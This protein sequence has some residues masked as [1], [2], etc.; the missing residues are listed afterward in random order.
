MNLVFDK[1]DKNGNP[2]PNLWVLNTKIHY[3]LFPFFMKEGDLPDKMGMEN[4]EIKKCKIEDVNLSEKFYYII[5]LRFSFLFCIKNSDI[6]LP[7]EIEPHIKNNNLKVIFICELETHKF[8]DIFVDLLVK[9]IRKN[10]WPEE[11]FYIIDNNSIH[12]SI[13]QKFNTNIN[14]FKINYLLYSTRLIVNQM[15]PDNL[16]LDKKFI[17]LCHNREPHH[18]RML[19]LSQLNQLKLLQDDI[20]NW[21]MIFPQINENSETDSVSLKRF[22]DYIDINNKE[23]VFEFSK[24]RK[25]KKVCFYEVNSTI[26]NERGVEYEVAGYVTETSFQNAYINIV[27]ETHFIDYENVHI[28]EKS[29][30]PFYFFQLPIFLAPYNHVKM[31][32]EEYGFYLFDNL[33]DHSYDDEKDDAKRFK[34]VVQEIVKLSKM[35]NEISDYYKKNL[36]NLIYNHN[37]IKNNKSEDIFREYILNI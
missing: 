29:F 4:V 8:Y 11:N 31:L 18:H 28:T 30:K 5:S 14:F 6:F 33:I 24:M 17:F 12:K 2:L 34:M 9:K 25:T 3:A 20:I 37:I 16:L 35:R 26:N 15:T 21:S 23:L 22:K 10:N 32:R 7:K 13:K 27:T 36:N 19:L 1:W